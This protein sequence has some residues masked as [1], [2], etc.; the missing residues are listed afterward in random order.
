[1]Q[2]LAR[3]FLP[4][5]LIAGSIIIVIG[6]VTLAQS[7][8]SKKK[9]EAATAVLVDTVTAKLESLNLSVVSQG[10]VRP[11]TE[12]ILAAEVPGKIV[13]VSPNFIAGGF[14]HRGEV[15]LQIDPSDYETGVKRAEA[16]L[17][18]RKA[19][20]ADQKARSEQA[21]KDWKNL[22]REGQPSDLT[23]HKPQ[24][25]EALAA[26]QAAE[27]DL[28]KAKRDLARTRITLPYEG[29]V[30]TKQADLGQYVA[31][32]TRL[33][34]TFA[35]ATA[36][37]RLPLTAGDLAFLQLP[38][39]TDL[40]ESNRPKV[41]LT[42]QS[43]GLSGEWQAEIIRTEGVVDE[44]SRVVYAVA[45]VVDPYAVLGKSHQ[46]ELRVGTFVRAEIQ[47]LH[48][49]N[50]IVLPRSVLRADN[51]VLVANSEHKLE[52]RP[53]EVLRAEPETVYIKN[54]IKAGE[55]VITT[56]MDIPVPGTL[57]TLGG[58]TGATEAASAGSNRE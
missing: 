43:S 27:A 50:V 4:L 42:A 23:L 28:Q 46:P 31:P 19:Q 25:A 12:T 52:I 41:R 16:N 55:Q 9:S 56:A 21:L 8:H 20:L 1:M 48:V 38:S 47:G 11:R 49:E 37:I 30:K 51:T 58:R 18:A 29:L 36:E 7:K 5:G 39:A 40:E 3:Y 13:S 10:T 54:G 6:L 17:A 15:L 24:L 34:V 53:V 14:F 35:I 44:A 32:G 22:G 2:K 33:G 26:V 57:L 45:E